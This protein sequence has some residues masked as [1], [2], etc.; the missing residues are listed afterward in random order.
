MLQELVGGEAKLLL[1]T[2]LNTSEKSFVVKNTMV[3]RK[4]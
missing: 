3:K 4:L 1:L 2:I